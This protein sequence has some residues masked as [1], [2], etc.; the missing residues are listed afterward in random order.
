M[1]VPQQR[2][3]TFIAKDHFNDDAFKHQVQSDLGTTRS[4]NALSQGDTV[5]RTYHASAPAISSRRQLAGQYARVQQRSTKLEHPRSSFEPSPLHLSKAASHTY[6]EVPWT[7]KGSAAHSNNDKY[8]QQENNARD[9]FDTDVDDDFDDTT[10]MSHEIHVGDSQTH[11]DHPP[12]TY[13]EDGIVDNHNARGIPTNIEYREMDYTGS[14]APRTGGRHRPS[15]AVDYADEGEGSESSEGAES[16]SDEDGGEGGAEDDPT[17]NSTKMDPSLPPAMAH[18]YVSLHK[19]L[20]NPKYFN[21]HFA[22]NSFENDPPPATFD[23]EEELFEP[24]GPITHH[25]VAYRGKSNSPSFSD[26]QL[27]IQPNT[28]SQT[29]GR[30]TDESLCV[31]VFAA[32]TTS[33]QARPPG[34]LQHETSTEVERQSA[35]TSRHDLHGTLLDQASAGGEQQQS[36]QPQKPPYRSQELDHGGIPPRP[37]PGADLNDDSSF[38]LSEPV[39]VSDKVLSFRK[40]LP[41]QP[42]LILIHGQKRIMDLDYNEELLSKM[43]YSQLRSESFDFDPRDSVQIFPEDVRSRPLIKQFEYVKDLKD[44]TDGQR[45][46]KLQS[47][48]SSLTIDEYEECGDMVLELFSNIL[49]KFKD[50]RQ[51]KREVARRYEEEISR[52]EHTVSGASLRVDNEMKRI[53]QAGNDL[54]KGSGA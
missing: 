21:Q 29:T 51:E 39:M 6:T 54:L 46:E 7:S 20:Q 30:Y 2:L 50:A 15:E 36:I 44:L 47:F 5:N 24:T 38:S 14:M 8:S 1:S 48:F 34:P 37:I 32:N 4:Q 13:D 35:N 31:P 52:R 40:D 12:V 22:E 17:L 45:S 10:T 16:E 19:A 33:I 9:G 27:I 41:H 49:A 26:I 25:K 53:R 28:S 42:D 11:H 3:E 23:H 18:K 43:S